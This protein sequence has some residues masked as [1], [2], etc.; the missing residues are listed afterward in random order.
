M[1]RDGRRQAIDHYRRALG[2][3]VLIGLEVLVAATIIKTITVTPTLESMG[4]LVFM[5]AIR[6]ALGWTMVLEMNGRW[7]WQKSRPEAAKK[8]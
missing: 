7:P 1:L 5:V 6:T 3:V 8:T 2:R 4:I